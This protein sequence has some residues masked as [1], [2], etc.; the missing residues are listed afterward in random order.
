M[1]LFFIVLFHVYGVCLCQLVCVYVNEV[2][3]CK[4]GCVPTE[5]PPSTPGRRRRRFRPGAKALMEIRKYQKSHALLLRKQPFA[6]LVG[7]HGNAPAYTVHPAG[8]G[9][10]GLGA[11][12]PPGGGFH[13][14]S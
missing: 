4:C 5:P 13:Q 7:S 1:L 14:P 9:W 12:G 6:R 10:T 3:S 2:C 11:R 8:R